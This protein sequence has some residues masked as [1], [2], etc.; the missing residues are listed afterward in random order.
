MNM[1]NSCKFL[2]KY[3]TSN[4][5]ILFIFRNAYLLFKK[6]FKKRF[7]YKKYLIIICINFYVNVKLS[8]IAS[9]D[10]TSVGRTV[11]VVS[12]LSSR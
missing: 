8:K 4:F 3:K 1:E 6:N 9:L 5:Y 2:Y 11:V 10:M 12:V 7:I